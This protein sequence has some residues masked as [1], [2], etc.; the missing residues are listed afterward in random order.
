MIKNK[1]PGI[2]H[3]YVDAGKFSEEEV[4]SENN[5]K[6]RIINANELNLGDKK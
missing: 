4:K 3:I 2:K 1:S 5:K 6:K